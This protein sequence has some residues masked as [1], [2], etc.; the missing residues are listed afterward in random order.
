LSDYNAL[1]STFNGI[2]LLIFA[3]L[4]QGLGMFVTSTFMKIDI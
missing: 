2:L 1:T 4:M 3:M